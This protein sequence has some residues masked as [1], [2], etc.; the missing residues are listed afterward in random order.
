MS[1]LLKRVVITGM[2]TINPLGDTLESYYSNLIAGVSGIKVWQS[3]DLTR[4]EC[5]IGGD[6]G[7]YDCKAAL[8]RLQ[9]KI[10]AARFKKTAQ[11]FKH[12]TFSNKLS[13]L[14]ALQAYTDA[15][16]SG[17]EDDPFRTSV[18]VAGHNF[19]SNYITKNIEQFKIEPLYIDP[20]MG[21]EGLDPNI[22][23]SI[24]EILGLRGPTFTLGA[25]CA[26]GN[27]ALRDGFR[28]ILMGE[29]DRSIVSGALF[30]MTAA[31]IHAMASLDSVVV[32]PEYQKN[33]QA[34]SRPFDTKRCGFVPAHGAATLVLEELSSA[35]ERGARIYAEV[36]GVKANANANHLPAPSADSMIWLIGELL[37]STGVAPSQIDY[38]NCHAT[39][40]P[41]GDV[42]EIRAIKEAFGAHAYRLK[43]NAPKSMLGHVCWSAAIVET[44]GAVLQMNHSML[45]PTIN[46]DELDPEVDLDVCA[47]EA[48]PCTINYMLKNSFGFGG[49]NCCSLL[50]KYEE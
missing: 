12:A 33:P 41:L 25:A 11:L 21:V 48:K 4:V 39:G 5:K 14:C 43:L 31:D 9:E 7:D 32:K 10:P 8:A 44:I 49:L 36:L 42:E 16:L 3:I 38:I 24:S 46:I 30:D 35:K 28:D 6:L 19:N 18:L 34:A 17:N 2:S 26:S 45:H 27:I 13:M 47:N 22:A 37:T 29:C 20:L 15:N 40:T 23:A 1:N 50:K